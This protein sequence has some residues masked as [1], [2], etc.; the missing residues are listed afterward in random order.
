[1]ACSYSGF[2]S[3]QSVFLHVRHPEILAEGT[4]P[5]PLIPE[6]RSWEGAGYLRTWVDGRP[7]LSPQQATVGPSI[8]E[9]GI[10]CYD[11]DKQ[12]EGRILVIIIQAL[13][14]PPKH[15]RGR[16]PH[17]KG[18]PC[19]GLLRPGVPSLPPSAGLGFRA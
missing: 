5:K 19:R 9:I 18:L 16:Q 4:K 10:L 13:R 2:Y 12:P 3:T 1:M 7:A 14:L 6:V 15:S 8:I 11:Y 17:A